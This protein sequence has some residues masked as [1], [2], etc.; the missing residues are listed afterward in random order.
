LNSGNSIQ[1]SFINSAIH[2]GMTV[3]IYLKSG[4]RLTGKIVSFTPHALFLNNTNTLMIYKKAISTI[5]PITEQLDSS[6][7]NIPKTEI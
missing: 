6:L 1:D 7:L 4:I 2:E 5:M 3:A